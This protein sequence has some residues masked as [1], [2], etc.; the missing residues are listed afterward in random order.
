MTRVIQDTDRPWLPLG[1]EGENYMKIVAVDEQQKQVILIVK[2]GPHAVYPK[3]LHHAGAI[4]YTIE[5]EWEY[6]EGVLPKGAWAV[7]PPGTEHTPVVS[8]HG[9]TILAVLTSSD[10]QYVSIPAPDGTVIQQDFAYFKRL[11]QMTPEQAL[12]EQATGVEMTR[13]E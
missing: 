13:S 3:H 4:A 11:S 5:G 2:F 1:G 7:E 6:E 12:A 9:A 10:D 8:K